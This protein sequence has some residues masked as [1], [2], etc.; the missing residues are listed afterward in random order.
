MADLGMV[1]DVVDES[2]RPIGTARRSDVLPKKLGF[3]TVH[4]FLFEPKGGLLLQELPQ[5]HL[6]SPGKLG[7]SVAGY[8]HSGESYTQAAYR[9]MRAELGIESEIEH[10][11]T[12]QMLDDGSRKFVALFAGICSQAP[13]F[14]SDEIAD[15]CYVKLKS[16]DEMTR[17]E[18]ERFTAT[19]LFAYG[20]FRQ[21]DTAG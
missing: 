10:V 6:R 3:R 12:W 20:R 5:D 11:G 16:L 14:D 7:S 17:S 19:F 4:V 2:N 15:V 18:P 8:L 21:I 1:V 13:H 9:K